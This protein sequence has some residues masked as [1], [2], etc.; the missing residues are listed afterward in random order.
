MASPPDDPTLAQEGGY[1][2]EDGVK[3]HGERNDSLLDAWSWV[4]LVTGMAA[5]WLMNPFV[6]LLILI[7]WEPLEIFI[8]SPLSRKFFNYPFGYESWRNSFS[9]V[10]FDAVG[11]AIGYYGL[12]ALSTPPP[13]F[14]LFA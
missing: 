5:G 8:L 7:A 3:W 10:V 1:P 9:D 14:P 4:H 12:T 6:A 13:P 2:D 11:V